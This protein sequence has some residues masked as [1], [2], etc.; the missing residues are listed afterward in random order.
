MTQDRSRPFS[1][2]KTVVIPIARVRVVQQLDRV[3]RV[4]S[5]WDVQYLPVGK[6]RWWWNW[7]VYRTEHTEETARLLADI[8][9]KERSVTLTSYENRELE[10]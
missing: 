3:S 9:H 10:I 7:R 2:I 5:G 6:S 8:L 4:N 1:A